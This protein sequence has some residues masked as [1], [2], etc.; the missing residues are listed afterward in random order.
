MTDKKQFRSSTSAWAQARRKWRAIR[1]VG[2]AVLG[3][4]V[5]PLFGDH[6]SAANFYV[7]TNG[8]DAALGTLAQPFATLEKARDSMR[9]NGAGTVYVRGGNY[10]RTTAFA[11]TS[12]DSGSTWRN[13]PGETPVIIGGRP[14]T[15]F[16]TWHTN[17]M[18]TD[19]STQGFGNHFTQL[20]MNGVRQ[21]LARYPNYV[22]GIGTNNYKFV[23]AGGGG[24]KTQFGYNA[25][26]L[27]NYAHPTELQAFVFVGTF[28]GNSIVPVASIDAENHVVHL[29]TS[30]I[31]GENIS[32]LNR[33]YIQNALEELDQP[34]EWYLDANSRYL[35]FWPIKEITTDD[36]VYAPVAT[37][38]ITVGKGA[39]NITIQG[40]TLT[41]CEGAAVKMTGA[42]N[43]LV[44][45]NTVVNTG[46]FRESGIMVVGGFTNGVVG[47]DIAYAGKWGI[48]LAGGTTA[49]LSPGNNYADNNYIHDVGVF[50]KFLGVGILMYDPNTGSANSCGN[51]ASRN[52]ILN[53]PRNAIFFEGAAHQIISNYVSNV[54][55]ESDD[56][57]AF[58]AGGPDWMTSWGTVIANNYIEKV[59][60]YGF[61]TG[62][63]YI[64]P[65]LGEGIYL[66]WHVNGVTISNNIITRCCG[67][68][69]Y[70]NGGVENHI[71]NN[72]LYLNQPSARPVASRLGSY[73]LH[74]Y[75]VNGAD[76]YWSSWYNAFET[77][78]RTA[79]S[80]NY[81]AWMAFPGFS[82]SPAE[83]DAGGSFTE[84]T[85]IFSRNI[86]VNTNAPN[87]AML[88]LQWNPNVD[89]DLSQSNVLYAT[90]VD[91]NY[92][93]FG[94]N[95][96]VA[97]AAQWQ[98]MGFDTQSLFGDPLL[99][100]N[101]WQL[102]SN[103][104]ALT[105]LG[106]NQLATNGIGCSQ[107]LFRASWPLAARTPLM[108][109]PQSLRVVAMSP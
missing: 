45:A 13:F 61:L 42:T 26:D 87:L 75:P 11:L 70:V 7:A 64:L 84:F 78:W 56:G 77:G 105:M 21:R 28:C 29:S 99:D 22:G 43:C 102:A 52:T 59:R 2:L 62:V 17:V 60:S 90:G 10:F 109:S 92:S 80:A 18:V 33:Y 106:F 12:T 50:D 104:P 37:N 88:I 96:S 82:V 39:A 25:G 30:V 3:F 44:A 40:L 85:N 8:S 67:I 36:L 79:T 19:V 53:C 71:I 57:G 93:G 89:Q 4:A 24:S 32:D 15:N 74:G 86:V 83:I 27:H 68:G 91:A 98:G 48:T 72:I 34:G 31:G 5:L 16:Q 101:T 81:S 94:T 6:A 95:L 35:Y 38:L 66:D 41:C 20:L 58:Y 49:S 9:S 47:N 46:G 55:L 51:R 107:G 1:C 97:V 23:S 69:I 73:E 14:L 65:S 54:M 100:P 63:G 108:P 103:S 76:G